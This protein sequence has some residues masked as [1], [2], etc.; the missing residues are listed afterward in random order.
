MVGHLVLAVANGALREAVLIPK[1]GNAQGL[2]LRGF[3]LS[4]LVLLVAYLGIPWLRA[5]G[6]EL[7]VIGLWWLAATLAFEFLFGLIRGKPFGEFPAAC[8][9]KG[10]NLWPVVLLVVA[11]APWVA[12]KVRD[13]A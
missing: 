10:G 11:V 2:I 1:L 6:S 4:A 7:I 3:L 9:F 8:T 13:M 12:G 5:H